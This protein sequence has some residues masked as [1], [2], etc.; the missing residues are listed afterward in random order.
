MSDSHDDQRAEGSTDAALTLPTLFDNGSPAPRPL[1]P[2]AIPILPVRNVVLFPD[3]ALPVSMQ[4][5]GSVAALLA[6]EAAGANVIGLLLQ[7]EAECDA[8]RPDDLHW[9]GT[10][11]RVLRHIATPD[12]VH[13]VI[14]QG[15]VRFRVLEFL[16]GWPFLVARIEH[17][18][19]VEVHTAEIEARAL[20][21]R[22][23]AIE[24]L[25][26]LPHAGKDLA[27]TLR[28]LGSAARL[29]D[30]V[31]SMLDISPALRQE[32]LET[33]DLRSRLDK[34]IR[35]LSER[36]HVLKL[37][38]E[39]SQQTHEAIGERQREAIL[40]E[41][42]RTI[43]KELG[44]D[45]ESAAELD[46]LA[47]AL[48]DAG[49]PEGA[50]READ[51]ELKRL[52]RLQPGQGEYAMLR[53]YLELLVELPWAHL[54]EERIDLDAARAQLDAD[55]FGLDRIKRRILEYLAVRKLNPAG[56]APILCFV[57]PPG[58]G[59]T[60]LGQSIA[61]TTGRRFARVALGG[62]HDEAEIRGHRR[63]YIGAMPGN[64]I[65]A[66]RKAGTRNPVLLFDEIDK[67]TGGGFHGDPAAAL[68]EVLDP[69]QNASFRD[70]YLGVDFDLSQ[71][72]FVCTANS[73][74]GMPRP[75]L[76]RME[77]IEVPSYSQEEK[78]A[79]ARR[80][81]L[82]RQL[83]QNGL[84]A[85]G[86]EVPDDTLT[87]L[88]AAYTR[89]A[90]VR[91]LEREIGAVC[92]GVAMR[93][94]SGEATPIRVTP[95]ALDD[96]LGPPR[97]EQELALRTS[98]A[99]VA[100]GLAWTPVGG[101]ILFVEATRVRGSGR[102]I[103]TGQLGEV[104]KESAQAAWSLARVQMEALGLTDDLF[105]KHDLHLHVPA[106]ATPKDGPSAGVAMYL[107]IVSLLTGRP[108]RH[109]IAV[110]GE[111]SLR[112]LV[113]PVGGIKE[114]VLAALRSGVRTV[115]LPARN[116]KDL[117]D[118]PQEQRRRLHFVFIEHLSE[119]LEEAL[120]IESAGMSPADSGAPLPGTNLTAH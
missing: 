9:V 86:C 52:R 109:D 60:S 96:I 115:M 47:A 44:D 27:G 87:R 84:A 24:A 51:R 95:Q 17:I 53:S 99:G 64:V 62:V 94:A 18:R 12:D 38:H 30:L 91:N 46:E 93:V 20:N 2:D 103:L 48:A 73:L 78:L 70:N 75:L 68:L 56:R 63:T 8:P 102:L 80:Y 42:I 41:Q 90:G 37:S 19:E 113:L 72:L 71:V 55:H 105:E 34:L 76:D 43:Q 29:T 79:I 110:T 114:K 6:A 61:A 10:V 31:A 101:D 23:L 4:R 69:A 100:T 14:C 39:I 1:P 7:R 49:L 3:V 32:I 33:F 82:G 108:L 65:Q 111:V 35:L 58:V 92:R 59:K 116:R 57:G 117:H 97:F 45:A 5:A 36:L 74:E 119:A 50:Q 22:E 118:I 104:M 15:D 107:A 81:L 106:G 77:I 112:G 88:I 16:D 13:H 120:G 21:L 89:E 85:N 66:L 54:E 25:E 11:A 26:Y 98:V 83:E 67:T 28:S 40:R